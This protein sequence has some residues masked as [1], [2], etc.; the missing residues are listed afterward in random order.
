[1]ESGNKRW[2]LTGGKDDVLAKAVDEVVE[3]CFGADRH[4]RGRVRATLEQHKSGR[5]Q[6]G[7]VT[8]REERLGGN[9]A[10]SVVGVRRGQ[11]L[12]LCQDE[13]MLRDLC[14]R[15]DVR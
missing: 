10:A 14:V 15:K 1:M 12:E 3:D 9:V 7:D 11:L 4:D 5:G 2:R 8:H 6:V 13:A